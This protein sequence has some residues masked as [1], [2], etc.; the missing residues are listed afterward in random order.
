MVLFNFTCVCVIQPGSS[1][2]YKTK[3][4]DFLRTFH[5]IRNDF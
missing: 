3:F 5:G 4:K 1:E 2:N